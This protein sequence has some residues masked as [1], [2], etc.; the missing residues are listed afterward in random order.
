MR[1]LDLTRCMAACLLLLSVS[2]TATSS[3]RADPPP[4]QPHE[5]PELPPVVAKGGPNALLL[6]SGSATFAFGYAGAAWVG[7][8]S[9]LDTDRSLLFPIA[10]PWVALEARAPCGGDVG[11]V[12]AHET[13]YDALL[14]A[15]GIVQLAGIA[16]IA[17]AFMHRDLRSDE[18]PIVGARVHVIPSRTAGGGLGMAASGMF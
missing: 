15:D 2:S 10:G 11:G 5:A 18:A 16:Q 7:A 12:C 9:T 1:D 13:T 4:A 6:T 3:A 8:T 14:I 17:L